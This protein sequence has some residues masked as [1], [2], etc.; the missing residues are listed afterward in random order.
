MKHFNPSSSSLSVEYHG[1]GQRAEHRMRPPVRIAN[2]EATIGL[3]EKRNVVLLVANRGNYGSY[4]IVGELVPECPKS[5]ALP[6]GRSQREPSPPSTHVQPAGRSR[7]A[8][9]VE[10]AR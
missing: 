1:T 3:G 4:P 8:K 9:F 2:H 7:V 5:R 6:T 10:V